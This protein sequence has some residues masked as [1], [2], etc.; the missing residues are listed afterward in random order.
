MPCIHRP[1][2]GCKDDAP[3]GTRT[4]R[5]RHA[6]CP[7]CHHQRHAPGDRFSVSVRESTSL[8]NV[9]MAKFVAEITARRRSSSPP[10]DAR[11]PDLEPSI[12]IVPLCIWRMTAQRR[13]GS[14]RTTANLMGKKNSKSRRRR[15]G[16]TGNPQTTRRTQEVRGVRGWSIRHVS[17]DGR[18]SIRF[19]RASSAYTEQ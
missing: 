6:H 12:F 19:A 16:K 17:K 11:L 1:R 13:L 18:K 7:R 10:R 4:Q 5:S 9:L 2:G 3:P 14:Q 15:K 8:W